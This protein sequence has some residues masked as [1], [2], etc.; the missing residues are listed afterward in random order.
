MEVSVSKWWVLQNPF[1]EEQSF[2]E[3]EGS[4]TQATDRG[5]SLQSRAEEEDSQANFFVSVFQIPKTS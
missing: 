2:W 1:W 5:I 3:T 4:W